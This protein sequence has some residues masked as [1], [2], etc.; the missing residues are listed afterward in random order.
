MSD[1]AYQDPNWEECLDG[2]IVAMSPRPI[3]NHNRIIGN[4]HHIF[5]HYLQGKRCEVFFDEVDVTLTERDRVIPDLMIVC[6]PEKIHADGVYGA[7]DL[8]VEVLSPGTAKRDRGYKKDL[9][10][11][12]GVQEYWIVSPTDDSIEVYRL[13]QGK[14][15][16]A[17]LYAILP[18]CVWDKMT[19]EEKAEMPGEFRCSL[20][21]DLTISLADVFARTRPPSNRKEE[22]P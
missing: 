22:M 12:C 10:E 16:L 1:F 6:D 17:H 11:R 8:I 20:F 2:K 13:E 15:R 14:Y 7:P 18:D 3:V 4:L 19:D 21:E 9:Y 5:F